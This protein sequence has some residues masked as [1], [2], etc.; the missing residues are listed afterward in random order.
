MKGIILSLHCYVDTVGEFVKETKYMTKRNDKAPFIKV[1]KPLELNY[2]YKTL[3]DTFKVTP[4]HLP[5]VGTE[6][7][8]LFILQT[9]WILGMTISNYNYRPLTAQIKSKIIP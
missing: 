1:A 4:S 8:V 5:E 2:V 9:D 6:W 7:S 3:Q